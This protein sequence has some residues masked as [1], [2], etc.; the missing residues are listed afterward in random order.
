MNSKELYKIDKLNEFY[1]EYKTNKTELLKNKHFY[2]R[3]LCYSYIDFIRCVELP[4]IPSKS[5]WETVLIEYR[6]FPHLE[7]LIRN[8]IITLGEKWSHTIVCGNL[9]Y[10]YMYEMCKKISPNIKIIRTNYDNLLPTEYN[11]FLTSSSF[12][13][14]FLGKKILIYQ[15]DTLLFK[16]NI[17]DFIHWDYIGAPFPKNQNDTPNCVGNGGFSLRTRD[18]MI[19]VIETIKVEETIYE[20]STTEYMKNVNLEFPPEDVYF[21]KNMQDFCIGKVADWDSAFAFS[22]ESIVNHN[23]LGGHKFW[24]S[25]PQW[26]T[27]IKKHF[28]FNEYTPGSYIKEYLNYIS[29]DETYNKNTTIQNAFD[30]DLYFCNYVNDLIPNYNKTNIDHRKTVMEFL[31]KKGLRG[32]IYHSKQLKNIFPNVNIYQ[33][34]NKIFIEN[35]LK[36]YDAKVFVKNYLYHL[37]YEDLFKKLIKNK[38]DN[39]NPRFSLLLLVFVGNKKVGNN[40]IKK[41]IAYKSIQEC[42]IAFCFNSRT[43]YDHFKKIIQ[44]HFTYYSIY[45]SN[46]FGTDITP[47]ILMYDDISRKYNFEHIIKL[48]TKSIEVQYN[49]LTDYLLEIPLNELVEKKHKYCNCIGYD[50]YYIYLNEDLFNKLNLMET[51]SFLDTKKCFVGGTIFYCPNEVFHKTVEFIKKTNFHSY[52]FNNLYENNSI[53]QYYSPIHF[54]ERVFGIIRM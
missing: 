27:R 16:N 18:I 12:W 1:Q 9:N 14:L 26:K 7:F 34:S 15:E 36:I 53:N 29:L 42:N 41:I 31:N 49:H 21:S 51:S 47:T 3:F 30:V 25:D 22:S 23:S 44:K 6:C 45:L 43:I 4:T 48:H 24:I 32:K 35:N 19:Q 20:T 40:L 10:T 52:L 2:F 5:E 39:L 38:Y 54:L 37:S 11:Q 33:F 17:E 13:D 46:E 28:H 50:K 8:T